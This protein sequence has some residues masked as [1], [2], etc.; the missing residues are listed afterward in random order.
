MLFGA[1]N[2]SHNSYQHNSWHLNLQLFQTQ[3]GSQHLN[4]FSL[5]DLSNTINAGSIQDIQ[6]VNIVTYY[7]GNQQQGFFCCCGNDS[8]CVSNSVSDYSQTEWLPVTV[9]S[10][11]HQR[12]I[13]TSPT[14]PNELHYPC[15]MVKS[16][17]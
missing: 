16:C 5:H 3:Q 10:C 1:V 11:F 17:C 7:H 6:S 13:M 14:A 9:L 2:G 15:M 12:R 8:G 4:P